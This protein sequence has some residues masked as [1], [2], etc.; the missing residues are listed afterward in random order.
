MDWKKIIE[1]INIDF[2]RIAST[3]FINKALTY[4]TSIPKKLKGSNSRLGVRDKDGDLSVSENKEV[5]RKRKKSKITFFWNLFSKE[6]ESETEKERTFSSGGNEKRIYP[7]K[8]LNYN[9]KSSS[10]QTR[11]ERTSSHPQKNHN[12]KRQ[13]RRGRNK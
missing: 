12:K 2:T 13:N 3:F 9:K 4:I 5:V 11:T 8:K 7:P 10:K 1:N 6:T